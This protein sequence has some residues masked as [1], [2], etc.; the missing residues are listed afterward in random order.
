MN[1]ILILLGLVVVLGGCAKNCGEDGAKIQKATKP[2]VEALVAH[3]KEHGEPKSIM[4]VDGIPYE[5]TLCDKNSKLHEC[6]T[7][8]QG[9][10]FKADNEYFTIRLIKRGGELNTSTGF[11]LF[12]THSYTKCLYVIYKDGKLTDNYLSPRCGVLSSCGEGWKQ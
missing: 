3:T 7:L 9:Y 5:L 6:N 10:F 2:I 4:D 8:K 1:K 12:A 11:M